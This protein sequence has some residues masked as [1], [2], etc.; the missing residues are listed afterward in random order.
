MTA[1]T[2]K[3][4]WETITPE[5]AEKYLGDNVDNRRVRQVHVERL[6]RDMALG[7]SEERYAAQADDIAEERAARRRGDYDS[8]RDQDQLAQERADADERWRNKR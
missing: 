6:A 3:S 7:R 8:E 2:P 5:L 4:S 1:P